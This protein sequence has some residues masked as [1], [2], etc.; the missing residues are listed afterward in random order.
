M[1]GIGSKVLFLILWVCAAVSPCFGRGRIVR[2]GSS[3][4]SDSRKEWTG[5]QIGIFIAGSAVVI[6]LVV[7]Y[8][9]LKRRRAARQRRRATA[10]NIIVITTV[11]ENNRQTEQPATYPTPYP[12]TT[13]SYPQQPYPYNGGAA[14]YPTDG[15]NPATMGIV[16]PPPYESNATYYNHGLVK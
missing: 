7:L 8:I 10:S 16:Q 14:P 3:S 4:G 5:W 15:T 12:D 6:A 2:T 13:K 1:E 9:F 11:R